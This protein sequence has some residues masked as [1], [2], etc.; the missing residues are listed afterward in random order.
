[1]VEGYTDVLA[2]H[3]AGIRETVA[4]MGTAL[5]EDQV[6]ELAKVAKRVVLALDADRAGQEAMLRAARLARTGTSSWRPWRCRRAPIPPICSP[7]AG[8]RPFHE[9]LSG[10]CERR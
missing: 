4:I 6:A 2:M 10:A 1:M 7:R 8:R 5:T 3:Q 9:R